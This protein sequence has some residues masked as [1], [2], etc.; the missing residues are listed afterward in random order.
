MKKYLYLAAAAVFT[1][2]A[3]H[4]DSKDE[5]TPSDPQGKGDVKEALDNQK[6][7]EQLQT[8]A[9]DFLNA[10]KPE[11]QKRAINV[12]N[13]FA[14][15]F[16]EN[17]KPASWSSDE[18]EPM[19]MGNYA[20]NLAKSLEKKDY[21][22]ATKVNDDFVWN[23]EEYTGVFEA[24]GE[25]WVK[26]AESSDIVFK[27]KCDGKDCE[28]KAVSSGNVSDSFDNGNELIKIDLPANV[29]ITLTQAGDELVKTVFVANYKTQSNMKTTV[30][31]TVA[32]MIV[33]SET[34]IT[35][36]ELSDIQTLSIDGNTLIHYTFGLKGNHFCDLD[37]FETVAQDDSYDE[38]KTKDYV[39]SMYGKIN[40]MGNVQ[41]TLDANFGSDFDKLDDFDH[42]NTKE[43]VEEYCNAWNN[44][45]KMKFFYSGSNVQQGSFKQQP[46]GETLSWG[47]EDWRSELVIEFEADGTTYAFE[48]YFNEDKFA[49]TNNQYDA[50][51][52]K[53]EAYW[54]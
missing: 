32:N 24:N 22:N 36:T 47:F 35:N 19:F 5:V 44:V 8:Y 42:S 17:D 48:D 14:D 51:W 37:H 54:K 10:F 26:T 50:L 23:F 21:A 27:F 1:L 28:F 25:E 39:E 31:L 40:V 7:K 29:T 49:D 53:Y 30:T 38:I 16:D 3:C 4:K 45:F 41:I 6:S 52:D 33:T 20:S 43:S 15:A 13:A 34:T 46:V 12:L 9:T 18:D 2:S 11:D